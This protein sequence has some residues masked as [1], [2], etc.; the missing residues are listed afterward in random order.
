MKQQKS[1]T[2]VLIGIVVILAYLII[3]TRQKQTYFDFPK[4]LDEV[5][6]VI[7]QEELTVRDMAFYIAY[8]EGQ[9]EKDA[10]VYNPEDTGE[11][12]KIFTNSTF[13]RTEAKKTALDMAIHDEIFYQLAES[14]GMELDDEEE[15]YLANTQY[16]FWSDLGDEQKEALG[17][18][19]DV[20]K[21]SMRKIALGEKYQKLLAAI[22]GEEFEA[23][24]FGGDAYQK[25][26]E[27]HDCEVVEEVWDRVHFGSITVDH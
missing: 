19:Q 15:K 18:G 13:V 16:D 2:T 20:L 24:S 8:E 27:E 1:F 10:S 22:N 9:V 3:R 4:A 26:L 21:E 14:E 6:A 7:D 5:V 25:L 17:V 11:Y 23:Y 12:W